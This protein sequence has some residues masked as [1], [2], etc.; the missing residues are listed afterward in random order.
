L[1]AGCGSER[2]P[3]STRPFGKESH[4]LLANEGDS[5][6]DDEEVT[7]EPEGGNLVERVMK[8]RDEENVRKLIDP[9][10]P[11]EEEVRDHYR[12][13]IPYRNWCPICV[14]AKGRDMDHTT[15]GRDRTVSEYCLDYCFPG[16]EFG[17]KLTIL[18]GKER[19]TGNWMATAVPT[20]GASGKFGVDKVLEFLEELGDKDRR[21]IIKND[22]E[23]SMKYLISDVVAQ[24]EEGR[25]ILEESPVKSS[26]SNGI[27]ERGIQ[28]MENQVRAIFLGLQERMGGKLDA[29][30][31]IVTF[32]PEYAAYLMNR[33]EKGKDG[34]VGYERVKGKKPTVL[35]LEFG[36]KVLYKV[37]PKEK[38][39]KINA[40]WEH[41]IFV[42]IRKRSNEIW[43][44]IKDS[45]IAV[46]S[47]KRLP[48][49]RR[50]NV[51]NLEW[52][53]RV[54]W[55]KYKDARDADGDMPEGVPAREIPESSGTGNPIVI[56]TR[57]KVP[58]EFYIKQ[59]DAEKHGYTRGCAGCSSWFKG[60]GR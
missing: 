40:R 19:L 31:R 41:G 51:E 52:V 46:R 36:E 48:V 16:D 17:F 22:Q 18:V 59:E 13:H 44:A 27:V 7:C 25:T 57:R 60:L 12:F 49:E 24:R 15:S 37:K 42:G 56:E 39:E 1:R 4:E 28:S 20:K 53:N 58:R 50:W 5:D 14:K 21:I 9:R 33:L 54:P 45:V 10:L 30:E 38:M 3:D 8:E 34:K 29:R 11:N 47:V 35:G 26:G 43:I 55:N 2:L 23:P 6:G 32:I